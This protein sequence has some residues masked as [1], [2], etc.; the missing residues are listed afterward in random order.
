[1]CFLMFVGLYLSGRL[2]FIYV[3]Q[4]KISITFPL[5]N[6]KV[7]IFFGITKYLL[8]LQHSFMKFNVAE[9]IIIS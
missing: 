4:H 9:G 8:P 1:M 7:E 5:S 2:Q 6:T 3:G